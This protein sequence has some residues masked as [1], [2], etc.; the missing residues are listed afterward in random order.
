MAKAW[1]CFAT[2]IYGK[3]LIMCQVEMAASRVA[4]KIKIRAAKNTRRSDL[5]HEHLSPSVLQIPNGG[6]LPKVLKSDVRYGSSKMALPLIA[7]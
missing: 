6:I 5:T 7:I 2:S 4:P 1:F 3:N